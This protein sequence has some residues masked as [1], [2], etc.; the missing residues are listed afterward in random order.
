MQRLFQWFFE[1]PKTTSDVI[2]VR[3]LRST[4]RFGR[5]LTDE[6]KAE[7]EMWREQRLRDLRGLAITS[8][9]RKAG[10]KSGG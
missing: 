1:L 2:A 3:L 7:Q 5:E 6:G 9:H 8:R 4:S 10:P